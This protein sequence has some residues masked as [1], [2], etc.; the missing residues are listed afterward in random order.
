MTTQIQSVANDKDFFAM[1]RKDCFTNVKR[2]HYPE[3]II[4]DRVIDC[5]TFKKQYRFVW[6]PKASVCTVPDD[7][8]FLIRFNGYSF[9]HCFLEFYLNDINTGRLRVTSELAPIMPD[10]I[11]K[12][13]FSCLGG[14]K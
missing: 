10:N 1:F 6:W 3:D 14:M 7:D 9:G 2:G 8:A 4:F 13:L 12:D 5:E 11:Y